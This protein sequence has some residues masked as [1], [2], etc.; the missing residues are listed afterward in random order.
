[1]SRDEN[2]GTYCFI[3][4]GCFGNLSIR[5]LDHNSHTGI[6]LRM[7]ITS[8][9]FPASDPSQPP[10]PAMCPHLFSLPS[11]TFSCDYRR[12]WS[13]WSSE[14][15]GEHAPSLSWATSSQPAGWR[16]GPW[17]PVSLDRALLHG[18]WMQIPHSVTDTPTPPPPH[19]HLHPT[20]TCSFP[21]P[22]T[23]SN[24]WAKF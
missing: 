12:A 19:L 9:S 18:P 5:N 23:Q 2:Q 1:M 15:E 10:T 14:L 22:L 17:L 8:A 13:L 6:H 21:P 11:I 4:K 20:S 24:F 7:P 3:N 16:A